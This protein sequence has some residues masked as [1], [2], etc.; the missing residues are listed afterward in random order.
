LVVLFDEKKDKGGNGLLPTL[1]I[2]MF[3]CMWLARV[4]NANKVSKIRFNLFYC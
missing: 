1:Y 2:K 3:K 4:W